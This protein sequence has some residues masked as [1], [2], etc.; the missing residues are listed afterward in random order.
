MKKPNRSRQ[1]PGDRLLE[2][3]LGRVL[4]TSDPAE[5]NR[6]RRKRPPSPDPAAA[7][8]TAAPLLSETATLGLSALMQIVQASAAHARGVLEQ[9]MGTAEPPSP[10]RAQRIVVRGEIG[11]FARGQFMLEQQNPLG[12]PVRFEVSTF[13]ALRKRIGDL[14]LPLTVTPLTD[15]S[16]AMQE[17]RRQMTEAFESATPPPPSITM[18]PGERRVFV[19]EIDLRMLKD[20]SFIGRYRGELRIKHGVQ[21]SI[22]IRVD[23]LPP[24]SDL[25]ADPESR[26]HGTHPAGPSGV[27]GGVPGDVPSGVPSAAPATEKPRG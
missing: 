5:P 20:A 26:H 18:C 6:A 11:D 7:R 8:P 12:G 1:Q 9:L 10:P 21:Q 17:Y 19:V 3:I 13:R 22:P 2:E 24:T 25:C 23:M 14:E 4:P 15:D 27:P 16:P